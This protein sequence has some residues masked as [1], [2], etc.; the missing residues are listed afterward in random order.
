[1]A[2]FDSLV[3]VKQLNKPEVSGYILDVVLPYLQTGTFL[4]AGNTGA[5][6]GIFYPLKSNPTGYLRSGDITGY[7]TKQ[8]VTGNNTTIYTYVDTHF[9]PVTNPSGFVG[10]GVTGAYITFV[11]TGQTGQF[12]PNSNPSGFITSSQ[13]GGVQFASV[14]GRNISGN[15]SFTG[16]GGLGVSSSGQ[17]IVFSGA[18]TIDDPTIVRTTG[19]QILTDQKMFTNLV[20]LLPISGIFNKS[21]LNFGNTLI[22][23]NSGLASI[24]WSTRRLSS[25][26]VTSLDWALRNLNDISGNTTLNWN[27]HRLFGNW[28]ADS[29][30]ISGVPIS[31]GNISDSSVVRTTGIQTITGEKTFRSRIFA[32]NISVTTGGVDEDGTA[33]SLS[34]TTLYRD[35]DGASHAAFN[36]GGG[37]YYNVNDELLVYM[38][39]KSL[40]SS[41]DTLALNWDDRTLVD[42]GGVTGLSWND[43]ILYDSS[44]IKCANWDFRRLYDS[45]T[46]SALSWQTRDLFGAWKSYNFALTDSSSGF[47]GLAFQESVAYH[48]QSLYS[49][50]NAKIH[51]Y[52]SSLPSRSPYISG[53]ELINC[54]GIS[55]STGSANLTNVVFKTGAQTISGQKTFASPIYVDTINNPSAGQSISFSASSL[56]RNDAGSPQQAFD[57]NVGAFYLADFSRTILMDS[58][59][60]FG[61][62]EVL[63][64]DWYNR[65]LFDSYILGRASLDW[66]NRK[67]LTIYASTSLDWENRIA[68]DFSG[69]NSIDWQNRFLVNRASLTVVDWASY[70]LNDNTGIKSTDWSNRVLYDSLQSPSL[71]WKNRILSGN[72]SVK[73]SFALPSSGL[74]L[75]GNSV[76]TGG[77]YYPLNSNPSGYLTSA[78]AGGVNSINV[79]GSTITGA[80]VLTGNN[81]ITGINVTKSGQTISFGLNRTYLDLTTTQSGIRDKT[82]ENS[83]K[84]WDNIDLITALDFQPDNYFKLYAIDGQQSADFYSRGLYADSTHASLSWGLRTLQDGSSLISLDWGNRILS[85][86]W[87]AQSLS[88]SGQSI[89]TGGPYYPLNSNPS[90]YLTASQAGGVN[91]INVTGATLSGNITL[92]GGS[93][94]NIFTS[95]Q[96]IKIFTDG[97]FVR[98]TGNQN[99]SGQKTFKDTIFSNAIQATSSA[100]HLI[101]SS[102]LE[103]LKWDTRQLL[104]TNNITSVDWQNYTLANPDVVAVNW[105][106]YALSNTDNVVIDWSN[107]ILYYGSDG[108]TALTW[109]ASRVLS[110]SWA[111]Q[112]LSVSGQ[113]V[114]TG[115]PYYPLKSNPSGYLTAAQAGGVNSLNVT[116]LTISG[117]VI[118]TGAGNVSITSS[119]QVITISGQTGSFVITSQTGQFATAANLA[120][121]GATLST[122]T[123]SSTGIFYPLNS[124]PSGYAANDGTYV[125]TT[126]VQT[127]N[128]QKTFQSGLVST[129]YVS[130]LNI[131]GSDAYVSNTIR[132]ATTTN[133]APITMQSSAAAPVGN[134]GGTGRRIA[135]YDGNTNHMIGIQAGGMWVTADTAVRFYNKNGASIAESITFDVVNNR[136]GLGQTTPTASI[137]LP[138]G[139]TGVSSAPIKFTSGALLTLP[140]SGIIE[141]NGSGFF[142]TTHAASRAQIVTSSQTGQFATAASLAS[143]GQTLSAWTGISTGIFYPYASNPSG[144]LTASTA[145]GVNSINVTGLTTSGS[146][147][148][149][150]IGGLNIFKSGQTITFSGGAGGAGGSNGVQS[151][152]ASGTSI[153]GAIFITGVGGVTTR[154]SGQT[155]VLDPIIP[156][157]SVSTVIDWRLGN[158]FYNVLTGNTNFTFTGD[159]DGQTIVVAVMNSEAPSGYYSGIWPSNIKWPN[160][161]LPPAQTSGALRMD[162]YTFIKIYTGIYGNAVQNFIS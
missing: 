61:N 41:A 137:H 110:G 132:V 72:W 43:R 8:E 47:N 77:P 27:T 88:V 10:T 136:I 52:S 79:T 143:T 51:F 142:I 151:I 103:S 23:D 159:R 63:S 148:F 3:R 135:L 29:L 113:S 32:S 53:F 12:Y 150:G 94:I 58:Y 155:I 24:R 153:S 18:A 102:S 49:N 109:G 141:Y 7:A 15:V 111:A 105:N 84:L 117:S 1:M 37:R 19:N 76:T 82:F 108:S 33:I 86:A 123:G 126:G 11:R 128:G 158:V 22:T 45:A 5:L 156:A 40:Y 90:G 119:G 68:S 149:T 118:F 107:Y 71:D 92:T 78:S 134:D 16:V 87:K 14:T 36:W 146:V 124:N 100:A 89:T 139:G 114:T 65:L 130:G 70:Y 116:G 127:I 80:I 160:N 9:Y 34:D 125:R 56:Y 115:G 44:H 4:I 17:T 54:I 97:T 35:S 162:V 6:T 101:D 144:Y 67:L 112:Q 91:N 106:T 73:G 64:V 2:S 30:T 69:V 96:L 131:T 161:H 28:S 75:S 20:A 133:L 98:T 50:G 60:L 154:T 81:T 121:T 31:T 48:L 42:E 104:D 147:I 83:F 145:G 122:W 26:S 85:G 99:V 93:G 120:S 13:V 66:E 39:R 57:W 157:K 140:E 59:W 152:T 46:S 74:T 55:G 62:N 138:A 25:G 95:G 129:T 38:E 21:T